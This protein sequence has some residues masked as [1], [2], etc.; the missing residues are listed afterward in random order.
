MI[1]RDLQLSDASLML[2]WM[3]DKELC[4]WMHTDFSSKTLDDCLSFIQKSM[5]DQKNLNY[6]VADDA[7]EY[8]GTV[9]LKHIDT[10]LGIAEFG[11]VVR[12][13]AMGK[14]F[15]SYAMKTLFEYG[16]QCLGLKQIFWCV[17]KENIR[18]VRFYS[19]MGYSTIENIPNEIADLYADVPGLQW[20][21]AEQQQEV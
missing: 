8:M 14:G 18:A 13:C 17:S 1:L 4:R 20:Y 10:N 19:K 15:S 7:N 6:A 2:E 21:I 5:V 11:I 9:S 12:R 16:F 3:H